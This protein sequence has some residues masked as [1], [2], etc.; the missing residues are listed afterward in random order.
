MSEKSHPARLVKNKKAFHEY[1]ILET[2]EAGLELCG[3]EVKS[4]RDKN[5]SL[6][7]SYVKFENGEAWLL[8]AHIAPYSHGNQFNHDSKRRR[9]LLLHKR[10]IRKL[11]QMVKEK[12]LT[13]VPLSFHLARG[14]VKAELGV[15]K[16]KTHADK[17]ETLKKRQDD[18]DARRA[19]AH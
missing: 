7:D 2:I 15:A 3:T 12:G 13:V 14:R 1:Q 10:E 8:N 6:A 11:T 5:I 18:L 19:M 17:R 9:R 4:C 16:G